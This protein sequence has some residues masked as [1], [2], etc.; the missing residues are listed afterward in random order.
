MET[1]K[2]S[3]HIHIHTTEPNRTDSDGLEERRRKTKIETIGA[4]GRNG[5]K[6]D[7]TKWVSGTIGHRRPEKAEVWWSGGLIVRQTELKA[8]QFSRKPGDWIRNGMK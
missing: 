4:R 7:G 1:H 8:K 5:T 6:R 2:S 3:N